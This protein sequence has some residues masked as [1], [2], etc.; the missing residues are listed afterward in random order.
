MTEAVAYTGNTFGVDGKSLSLDGLVAYLQVERANRISDQVED[1]GEDLK[2]KNQLLKEAGDWLDHIRNMEPEGEWS[3]DGNTVHLDGYSI[4]FVEGS[5]EA[6]ITNH[7]TGETTRIWGDPHV[8]TTGQSGHWD[9]YGQTTF[10]LEDGTKITID[11]VNYGASDATLSSTV[12]ITKGDDAIVVT[13]LAG[14]YDGA[15]NLSIVQSK[16]GEALD[17]QTVDGQVIYENADGH[18]WLDS[19]GNLI[20]SNIDAPNSGDGTAEVDLPEVWKYSL[21]TEL[22]EW[23][24]ANGIQVPD[25][26]LTKEM[27]ENLEAAI[28][29]YR[30]ALTNETELDLIMLQQA[31][32]KYNTAIQ[33]A[34]GTLKTLSD[35]E[36][37][38]VRNV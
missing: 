30:S 12:T 11:T 38:V 22:V 15:N 36:S 26:R 17:A 27:L 6:R 33:T 4:T 14:N 31:L 28:E 34:T 7:D 16:N 3:V 1:Y 32:S 29:T 18:G 19:N 35:T 10:A 25:G 8:S 5:M 21:P 37:S 13:G 24:E 2:A 20:T 9:F 23:L